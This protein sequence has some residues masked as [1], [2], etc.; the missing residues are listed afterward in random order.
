[1]KKCILCRSEKVKV[2]ER[3][4]SGLLKSI[5]YDTLNIDISKELKN[6]NEIKLYHCKNCNLDFFDPK[7]AGEA[8][9]YEELQLKRK[10]YYSSGR[11]E[12]DIAAQFI[13][14]KD[15][16][17]E[18]GSGSGFFAQK[19]SIDNYVGLEF[20]DEA[21]KKAAEN[22]IKLVKQSI[23]NYAAEN[24]E[25][26][27]IVCSFHVL[28]HVQDPHEFLKASISKM[29]PKGKLILAVP[30]NDSVLTSNHN[31][32]LNLPPHHITRWNLTSLQKII[33]VFDLKIV[34][35]KVISIP[36]V[37][38]KKQYVKAA[39]LKKVLNVLYPKNKI[40]INPEKLNQVKKWTD[41]LV[42]KLRLYKMYNQKNFIGEN[43]IFVFEKK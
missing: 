16:V 37:I 17:L 32:V 15:S 20:N 4:K 38:S 5:Y 31:H 19:I 41:F 22:Q 24:E 14:K 39:L 11:K 43:V 13:S 30:C 34:D 2:S 28:E 29:N 33:T 40:A 10:I 7:F 42:T 12:F 27:D 26:F 9:F 18:I 6:E 25:K 1:M 3:I 21:I 35:F 36:D 23:E 8:S